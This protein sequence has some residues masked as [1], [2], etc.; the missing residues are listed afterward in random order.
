VSSGPTSTPDGLISLGIFL[1]PDAAQWVI[2]RPAVH[3][4]PD[5]RFAEIYASAPLK[6]T[7]RKVVLVN[8]W[9]VP[10]GAVLVLALTGPALVTRL[11]LAGVLIS[12]FV[13]LLR[14]WR[15]RS[16]WAITP[17]PA[18]PKRADA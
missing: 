8:L 17:L 5:I 12:W 4:V 16:W 6:E 3:R 15:K 10:F 11:V 13:R 1:A 18:G 2:A 14:V 9:V 7:D